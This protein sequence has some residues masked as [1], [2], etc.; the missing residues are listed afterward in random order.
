MCIR[1][2][3]MLSFQHTHAYNPPYQPPLHRRPQHAD[4]ASSR[5]V[6]RAAPPT[7]PALT[8]VEGLKRKVVKLAGNKNGT[9]RSEAQRQ[10]LADV[11]NQLNERNP[12][13]APAAADL[14][15]TEWVICYTDSSGNSSG[16]LG[17]LV[18]RTG[19]RFPADTPGQYVNYASFLAGALTVE[20]QGE[21]AAKGDARIN[22][23]FK[24]TSFSFLGGLLRTPAKEF[25][26]GGL[27]AHWVMKYVD[28]DVRV[29][30]TNKGSI[31]VL[32]RDS[33]HV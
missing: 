17:P 28:Q 29:L 19:Q 9:D 15:G 14:A 8:S 32:V 3:D 13:A 16:K 2:A 24:S 5:L 10:E 12:T 27:K 22:L 33:P 4:R 7:S 18:G 30:E 25:P 11:I 26:N 20:L 21:Y 23:V 31:F 1:I 6:A